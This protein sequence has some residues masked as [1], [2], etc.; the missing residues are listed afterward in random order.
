M[1]WI[2]TKDG[3]RVNTEWFTDEERVKYAQIEANQQIAN[4]LNGRFNVPYDQ[5]NKQ[6]ERREEH[7]DAPTPYTVREYDESHWVKA[8]DV[9]KVTRKN[10]IDEAEGW[11]NDDGTYGTGDESIHVIYDDGSYVELTDGETHRGWKQKNIRGISISTGDY[12]TVWGEEYNSR[13][14]EWTPLETHEFDEDANLIPGYTNSYSGWKAIGE[15]KSR[16][17]EIRTYHENR[18]PGNRWVVEQ[19][20][21]G[22]STV[23]RYG[24]DPSNE[25][26]TTSSR[27]V[28]DRLA[29][30]GISTEWEI[31]N[32]INGLSSTRKNRLAKELGIEGRG[33]AKWKALA[34]R[35]FAA[36]KD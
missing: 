11:K 14:R 29:K 1:A 15:Y 32:W 6:E 10:A 8:P 12:E 36:G 25:A 30:R 22:M 7:Y 18:R 9:R 4:V 2:T 19:E 21:L 27:K 26:G 5:W 33:D 35:I 13:T 17:R 24:G 28:A 16:K 34:M 3:R 23:K 20:T 31:E